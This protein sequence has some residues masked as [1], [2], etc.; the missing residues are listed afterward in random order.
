MHW[1][2]GFFASLSLTV[3]LLM[4][5]PFQ[6]LSGGVGR[7]QKQGFPALQLVQLKTYSPNIVF[8]LLDA[9]LGVK[10]HHVGMQVQITRWMP[11]AAKGSCPSKGAPWHMEA[12]AQLLLSQ[13]WPK[14]LAGWRSWCRK[15]S[16]RVLVHTKQMECTQGS[17]QAKWLKA[18]MPLVV[19]CDRPHRTR[20]LQ[21]SVQQHTAAWVELSRISMLDGFQCLH[22][23]IQSLLGYLHPALSGQHRPALS[24]AT[25]L[26][27]QD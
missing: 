24:Q 22:C 14:V 17:E 4:K 11:L 8:S 20:L 6:D 16:A 7:A 2:S 13:T 23:L 27:Y 21:T 9:P 10:L 5:F 3:S 18:L 1:Q 15:S 19:A 12:L 25:L 26:S